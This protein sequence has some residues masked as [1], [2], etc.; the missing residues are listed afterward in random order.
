[1]KSL[2]V[3]SVQTRSFR[4]LADQEV[5]LGPRFNVLAGDNGQGKTNFLEAIYV[6]LTSKSFRTHKL[7]ELVSH[8]RV[9]RNESTEHTEP[10]VAS[11][12]ATVNEDDERR[13]Q[14]VGFRAGMRQ[15]KIDDKRPP[16]LAEFAVRSPVVVFHPREL[17]LSMGGSAERRK[18]LDRVA[19]YLAP[20]ALDA[21]S[22]YTQAMRSRQRA[23]EVRGP[24]ALELEAFESLMAEHGAALMD[25]RRRACELVG[26]RA[27]E[28]FAAI[29]TPGLSLTVEYAP[30]G[31]IERQAFA[32]EL[33]RH[34]VRDS[35]RGSAS[36]GPHR[37]DVRVLIGGHAARTDASQGQHRAIVLALKAAE[38]DVVAQSR[39]VRPILLLD[40]VS[41]ELDRDRTASLFAFLRDQRGQVI[42]TTTRPELIE[43]G[44]RMAI[45]DVGKSDDRVDYQV[46]AGLIQS[47][48]GP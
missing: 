10:P 12:K 17:E 18:L 9:E 48:P 13:V 37:D 16:S 15:A 3:S 31:A 47:V 43:V 11:V 25:H 8:A 24:E 39:D 26:A 45:P 35:H 22:R 21:H 7:A 1:L 42:L 20:A 38:I 30:G 41:S 5:A 32:D 29:G 36:K 44:S 6:A 27:K 28:V 4:N 14:V 23:L 33:A 2:Y 40:D 46:C 19:L 34:R